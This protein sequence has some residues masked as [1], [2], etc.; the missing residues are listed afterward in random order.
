M[1]GIGH[2]KRPVFF[3]FFSQDNRRFICI[4]VA[5]P[6]MQIADELAPGRYQA[7]NDNNATVTIIKRVLKNPIYL[8]RNSKDLNLLYIIFFSQREQ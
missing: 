4:F 5:S 8:R 6:L 7:N 1:R 3:C 2:K